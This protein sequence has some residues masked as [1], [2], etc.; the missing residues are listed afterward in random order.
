MVQNTPTVRV[1]QPT[2]LGMMYH[3]EGL[4]GFYKLNFVVDLIS[5]DRNL[6]CDVDYSYDHESDTMQ[7]LNCSVRARLP[8][9]MKDYST[10]SSKGSPAPNAGTARPT[11]GSRTFTS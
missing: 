6:F 3:V 5:I 7:V 8:V 4:R 11:L 1:S 10:Q 2:T 9:S